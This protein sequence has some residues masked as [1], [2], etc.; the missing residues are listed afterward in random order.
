MSK[1]TLTGRKAKAIKTSGFRAR[2]LSK[3]GRNILKNR[4]KKGRWKISIS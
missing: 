2:M 1:H 3:T 4:R